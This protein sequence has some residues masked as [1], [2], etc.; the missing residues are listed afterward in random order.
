MTRNN[1]QLINSQ[2][3]PDNIESGIKE[4]KTLKVRY[5]YYTSIDPGRVHRPKGLDLEPNQSPLS[6]ILWTQDQTALF[7]KSNQT[8]PIALVSFDSQ[9][10]LDPWTPLMCS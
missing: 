1:N 3:C 5:L 10:Y 2:I 7:K 9:V 4:K 8:K 6:P